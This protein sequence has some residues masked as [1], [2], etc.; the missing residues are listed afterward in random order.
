[1]IWAQHKLYGC[2][3]IVFR[4]MITSL[5]VGPNTRFQRVHRIHIISA[6][7]MIDPENNRRDGLEGT[8]SP[9]CDME[10]SVW[11]IN[12]SRIF[13]VVFFCLEIY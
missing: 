9:P 3:C 6:F 8:S 5:I 7:S 4:A 10:R 12:D 2:S 13:K 1:M 11:K